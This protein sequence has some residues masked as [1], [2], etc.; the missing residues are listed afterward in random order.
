MRKTAKK[1]ICPLSF[2]GIIHTGSGVG[3]DVPLSLKRLPQRR[4]LMKAVPS[5]KRI[6]PFAGAVKAV[7]KNLPKLKMGVICAF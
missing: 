3:Q 6:P 7:G 1:N 4:L 2:G 5:Q